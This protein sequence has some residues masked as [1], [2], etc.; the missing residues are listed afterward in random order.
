M[1]RRTL[2]TRK[3]KLTETQANA[4]HSSRT[5][6]KRRGQREEVSIGGNGVLDNTM[7]GIADAKYSPVPR[8]MTNWASAKEFQ[9]YEQAKEPVHYRPSCVVSPVQR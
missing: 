9:Q 2:L 4:T 1:S 6:W 8:G 5:G 3:G 7:R